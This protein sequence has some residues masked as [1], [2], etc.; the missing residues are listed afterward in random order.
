[1]P[2]TNRSIVCSSV[3][4]VDRLH[5]GFAGLDSRE[6]VS[7][8]FAGRWSRRLSFVGWR[9]VDVSEVAVRLALVEICADVANTVS[10]NPDDRALEGSCPALE[11]LPET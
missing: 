6:R 2:R 7:G 11:P 4:A 1:V 3:L 9:V 5:T 8:P 10:D